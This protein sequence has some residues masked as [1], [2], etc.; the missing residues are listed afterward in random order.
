MLA[1]SYK[2]WCVVF[3]FF[4]QFKICSKFPYI[5]FDLTH[6][7]YCAVSWVIPQRTGPLP[8]LLQS[9]TELSLHINAAVQEHKSYITF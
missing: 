6:L 1:V 5:F 3:F 9:P 2:F 4:I 7:R 8:R